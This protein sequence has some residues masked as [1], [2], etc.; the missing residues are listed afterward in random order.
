MSIK[1]L[2][3]CWFHFMDLELFW[4]VLRAQEHFW[5]CLLWHQWL[6]CVEEWQMRETSAIRGAESRKCSVDHLRGVRAEALNQVTPESPNHYY[7]GNQR[8]VHV[9]LLITSFMLHTHMRGRTA[10]FHQKCVVYGSFGADSHFYLLSYV[11]FAPFY[12]HKKWVVDQQCPVSIHYIHLT[13]FTDVT[14]STR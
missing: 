11:R 9:M 14:L 8:G 12:F 4:P 5:K 3:R 1:S 10:N 2:T 7:D 13:D 6:G